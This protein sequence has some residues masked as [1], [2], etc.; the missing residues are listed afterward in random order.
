MK[1][2]LFVIVSFI[3]WV[4]LLGFQE[5]DAKE[6]VGDKDEF[7]EENGIRNEIDVKWIRSASCLFSFLED[8]NPNKSFYYCKVPTSIL[9]EVK[10]FEELIDK[11]KDF[12]SKF[13]DEV[14]S[15]IISDPGIRHLS[16]KKQNDYPLE[17]SDYFCPYPLNL[18]F[19]DEQDPACVTDY[20]K[21]KLI[22]RGWGNVETNQ[23]VIKMGCYSDPMNLPE[24]YTNFTLPDYKSFGYSFVCFSL[25]SQKN[26]IELRFQ[27][28]PNFVH[29]Y[30]LN[31]R[32]DT[33]DDS[34]R[35]EI[36][37][38]NEWDWD[39][40]FGKDG[41]QMIRD[42]HG[43]LEDES[44]KFVLIDNKLAYLEEI[45]VEC[46]KRVSGKYPP[47]E[48]RI[49]YLDKPAYMQFIDNNNEYV[50]QGFVDGSVLEEFAKSM[51]K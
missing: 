46:V 48:G 27:H 23:V 20:A 19:R 41:N 29:Y 18:I 26:D 34:I 15:G 51:F 44:E 37:E 28:E 40:H 11:Y 49:S 30:E 8:T 6:C 7:W 24:F 10:N 22:E 32:K 5:I 2:L 4:F 21:E 17:V 45:C 36:V 12:K 1:P 16:P 35:M 3:F 42:S 38:I 25:T 14:Y 47:G 50:L 9:D 31:A 13:C 33:G 43:L 39:E